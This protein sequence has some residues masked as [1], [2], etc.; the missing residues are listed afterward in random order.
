MYKSETNLFKRYF[1]ERRQWPVSCYWKDALSNPLVC[2]SSV[3]VQETEPQS[4]P[5][6]LVST[7]HGSI[8]V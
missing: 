7:L 6:V 8:S 3:L 5:G 4:A 2:M 1:K